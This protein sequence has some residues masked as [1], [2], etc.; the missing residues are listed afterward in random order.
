[1]GILQSTKSRQ[2]IN[3]CPECLGPF[4]S[5]VR[6]VVA[7]VVRNSNTCSVFICESCGHVIACGLYGDNDVDSGIVPYNWFHENF[8]DVDRQALRKEQRIHHK[9]G[10]WG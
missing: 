7:S 4:N 5:Q 9:N 8:T 6:N 1:M 10:H 3:E 2:H